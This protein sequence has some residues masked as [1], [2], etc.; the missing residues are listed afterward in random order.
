[1]ALEGSIQE[2][3]LADILQL[4]YLQKKTGVL[5]IKGR[6][7]EVEILFSEGN[8]SDIHSEKISSFKRLSE[9][10]IRNG[11]ITRN[12]LEVIKGLQKK[13]GILSFIKSN[14]VSEDDFFH[15]MEDLVI[16]TLVYI[17]S[18]KEGTYE[19]VIKKIDKPEAYIPLDTQQLLMESMRIVDELLLIEGK[20]DL[21]VIYARSESSHRVTL[22]ISESRVF[23]LIDGKKDVSQLI[24]ESGME[25][26]ETAKSL[27]ALAEKE[28]IKPVVVK[29]FVIEKI[30]GADEKSKLI[31]ISVLMATF[32]LISFIT[33][34]GIF[35]FFHTLSESDR[36]ARIEIARVV[37]DKYYLQNGKFPKNLDELPVPKD[38]WGRPYVYKR[39]ENGYQLFSTGSDGIEGTEDDIY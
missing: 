25:F 18:W 37:I 27:I 20:L 12:D 11:I 28:Y 24:D 8:I 33:L 26:M 22:G 21:E 3:G 36:G 10:F 6:T 2:F 13:E 35:N 14:R 29:P 5:K 39:S 31:S 7:D 30:K 34:S 16:D 23:T 4:L 1:M 38:S 9:I 19:F 15:G 32:S 17:F